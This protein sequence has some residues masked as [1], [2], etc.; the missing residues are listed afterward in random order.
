[1]FNP[2]L[3]KVFSQFVT[4]TSQFTLSENNG[5]VYKPHPRFLAQNL[6]KKVRLIHESLR[7]ITNHSDDANWIVI[8]GSRV[9]I[10]LLRMGKCCFQVQTKI[11]ILISGITNCKQQQTTTL[12]TT[13]IQLQW[14]GILTSQN[15]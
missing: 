1:M 9:E 14:R 8:T 6:G 12:F 4:T 11:I 7:Y 10:F 15:Y 13:T 2:Y 3:P 5:L